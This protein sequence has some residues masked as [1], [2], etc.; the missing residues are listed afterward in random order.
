MFV[1]KSFKF[2]VRLMIAVVY[3]LSSFSVFIAIG[4]D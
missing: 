1:S 3:D 4:G 2:Y